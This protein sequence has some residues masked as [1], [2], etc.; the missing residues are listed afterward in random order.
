MMKLQKIIIEKLW[1]LPKEIQVKFGVDIF[2]F[3]YFDNYLSF[4]SYYV[5]VDVDVD[6]YVYVYVIVNDRYTD[7]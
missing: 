7:I 2:I 1:C 5:E 3:W 6:A 4:L